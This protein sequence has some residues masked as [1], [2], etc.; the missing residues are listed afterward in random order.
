MS[1]F[2][3]SEVACPRCLAIVKIHPTTLRIPL[4]RQR[5]EKKAPK[6]GFGGDYL[7]G[8]TTPSPIRDRSRRT[9]SVVS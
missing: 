7:P 4:H 2:P 3:R 1:D 6:C 9:M 5:N 8:F